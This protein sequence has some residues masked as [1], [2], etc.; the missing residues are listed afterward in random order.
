MSCPYCE[1]YADY[2]AGLE[3]EAR[4]QYEA[5]QAEYEYLQSLIKEEKYELYAFEYVITRLYRE[6]CKE[7]RKKISDMRDEI[8]EGKKEFDLEF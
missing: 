5:E 1:E 6:L 8:I 7:D 2:Q 3:V 4:A